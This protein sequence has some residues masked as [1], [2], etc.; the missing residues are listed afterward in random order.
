[1][2]ID[3]SAAAIEGIAALAS[4]EGVPVDA[5]VSCAFGSPYE[6]DIP[7]S[8]VAA[9]GRRLLDGGASTLTMADTTGMATP[10]RIGDVLGAASAAGLGDLGLH[11][12]ET[13]GTGLLNLYAGLQ[14]GVTRFD[15]SVGGIGGS[16]FAAGAAG[17]VATED[18]V[19][20]L[21]DLGIATGIDLDRLLDVSALLAETLGHPLPSRVAH[22]GPR[23]RLA[24]TQ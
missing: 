4:A 13:R 18:V 21:D 19:A 24:V 12:H 1:M 23:T 11:L 9:L 16:P 6:G 7:P 15:T 20:L 8:S 2:T 17:N 5:V 22:A 3:E 14:R 10:R